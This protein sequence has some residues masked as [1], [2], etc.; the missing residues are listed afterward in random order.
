MDRNDIDSRHERRR[1]L[2]LQSH[3]RPLPWPWFEECLA[4][5]RRW[6]RGQGF[7]YRFLDD[8]LFAPLP[9]D[10]R[11]ATR[12]QPVVASD[13]AR[14]LVMQQAL[15]DGYDTAVWLDA[16]MLIVDPRRLL[17]PREAYAVGREVWVQPHGRGYRAWV[18]VHNAFLMF[19]AG[20]ALLPFYIDSAARLVRRHR[21]SMVPQ[22]LGPKLLTALHNVVGFPVAEEAAMLSPAVQDDLLAGG[23]AAL[24]LF[25][26][27]SRVAPAAVN[28]CASLV[29]SGERT[30]DA[31]ARVIACLHARPELLAPEG[32]VP[33][34]S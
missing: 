31:V 5:V 33:S 10:I 28:L 14:L 3:R 16:D 22:L 11:R 7:D 29:A 20:N 32:D 1:V 26:R 27:R 18:K 4:S 13:L 12:A 21:G 24:S 15:S 19:R 6:A 2:V 34:S 17:L 9:E 8:A 25:Q 30:A 23:G